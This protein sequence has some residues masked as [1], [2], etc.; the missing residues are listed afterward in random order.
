MHHDKTPDRRF[1]FWL[2]GFYPILSTN[3]RECL[4]NDFYWTFK[5]II[6]VFRTR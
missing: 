4:L 3:M 1:S 6:R 2:A 5:R